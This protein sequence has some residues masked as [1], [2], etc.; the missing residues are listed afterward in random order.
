M[1][2]LQEGISLANNFTVLGQLLVTTVPSPTCLCPYDQELT[3][4]L[5]CHLWLVS[6]SRTG[7]KREKTGCSLCLLSSL[8]QPIGCPL[9]CKGTSLS[10][11]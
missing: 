11:L 4:W 1:Y 7:A 9:W 3:R 5:I 10:V 8:G 2:V 6:G